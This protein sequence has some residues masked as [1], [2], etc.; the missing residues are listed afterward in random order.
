MPVISEAGVE[1]S[2][3]ER[4][5]YCVFTRCFINYDFGFT[6]VLVLFKEAKP[7]TEPPANYL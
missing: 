3:E 4:I 6:I 2:V 1:K 5:D 7:V